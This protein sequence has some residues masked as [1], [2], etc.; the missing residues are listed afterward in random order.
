[1]AQHCYEGGKVGDDLPLQIS[2]TNAD[3]SALAIESARITIIDE[4]GQ[5][6]ANEELASQVSASVAQYVFTP[7]R[8]AKY[9]VE[10]HVVYGGGLD[11][12]VHDIELS[13][14]PRRAL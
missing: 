13:V 3:G 8:A 11:K 7:T 5:R 9:I 10:W 2:L 6:A 14:S 1:M 4:K 12:Y